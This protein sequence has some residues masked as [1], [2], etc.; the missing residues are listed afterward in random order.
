MENKEIWKPICGYEGL[1]EVSNLGRV[2]SLDRIVNYN[3][4]R[5]RLFKSCVL[6]AAIKKNG[7]LIVSLHKNGEHKTPLVHRLV[8]KAFI[9]NPNNLP[10][11]N[12]INEIKTD[13][14][15]ENLEWVTCKEN[16]EYSGV[17]KKSAEARSQPIIQYTK[18]GKFVAEYESITEAERKNGIHQANISLVCLGKRKST[19]GYI[20]KFKNGTEN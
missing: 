8:A 5:K 9:P 4:G 15:I 10:Q 12:H 7:Y 17:Y 16:L 1:Y 20:W 13:N 11:V 2:R 3:D 19:G 6:K 18:D 14:R